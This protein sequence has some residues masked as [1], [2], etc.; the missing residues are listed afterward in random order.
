MCCPRYFRGYSMTYRQKKPDYCMCSGYYLS[1]TS[2]TG[3]LAN[4]CASRFRTPLTNVYSTSQHGFGPIPRNPDL[5]TIDPSSVSSNTVFADVIQVQWHDSDRKI[6]SLLS[7]KAAR[8]TSNSEALGTASRTARPG[9]TATSVTSPTAASAKTGAAADTSSGGLS[10]GAKAGIGGGCSLGLHRCS[11]GCSFLPVAK[12]K[13]EESGT[14][15][16][17][18]YPGKQRSW[19]P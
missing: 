2:T 7:Q 14:V 1:T 17:Q 6:I 13:A 3:I 12:K 18:A 11:S 19:A 16:V 8:E 15:T 5:V 10:I 4:F 9:S